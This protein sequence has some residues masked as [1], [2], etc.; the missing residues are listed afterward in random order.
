MNVTLKLDPGN[1]RL[2]E[3]LD[4]IRRKVGHDKVQVGFLEGST[5]PDG[6]SVPM[7]AY[8]QE[9]GATIEISEHT[10]TIYRKIDPDGEFLKG[11]RFVKREVSN[12]ATD[13]EVEAYT[14][15]IPSRPFMR[16][17]VAHNQGQWGRLLGAALKAADMD[18]NK[19]LGLVGE[20]IVGQMQ[21]EIVST[22]DPPNSPATIAAKGASKPLVETGH[23]LRSV[24]YQVVEG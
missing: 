14:V 12:F 20:K 24:A 6:T 3:A 13:H 19:A 21:Q 16:N 10:Q 15:T 9:F 22:V 23:M 5:Y 11:G 17:T 18:G 8:V 1:S 2:R 7:V 4:Q